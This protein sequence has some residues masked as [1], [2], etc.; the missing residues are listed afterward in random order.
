VT[1]NLMSPFAL[2]VHRREGGGVSDEMDNAERLT[3]N[4][5]CTPLTVSD[6]IAADLIVNSKYGS[7][8]RVDS[9]CR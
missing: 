8:K 5:Y 7:L 4:L 3:C 9:E 2:M 6:F 1:A